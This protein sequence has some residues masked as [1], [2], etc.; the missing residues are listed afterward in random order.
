MLFDPLC[1]YN[2][3]FVCYHDNEAKS[4][5]HWSTLALTPRWLYL[6]YSVNGFTGGG[7]FFEG[8]A[9][10]KTSPS[11][12]PLLACCAKLMFCANKTHQFIPKHCETNVS[13]LL[14]KV[15]TNGGLHDI[16]VIFITA[17]HPQDRSKADNTY[18][19]ERPM[20]LQ[21]NAQQQPREKFILLL[22]LARENNPAN[23]EMN[24]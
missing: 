17:R 22:E 7:T 21:T 24:Y 9:E 14:L 16:L 13:A 6:L 23:G 8:L 19:K 3:I 4:L 20:R 11:F 10:D 15:L 18:R 1:V 5:T 12:S 2:A